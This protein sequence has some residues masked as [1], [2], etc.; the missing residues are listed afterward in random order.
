MTTTHEINQKRKAFD[1]GFND[2]R[3]GFSP[4]TE[5]MR[6]PGND[7]TNGAAYMTGWH[8][9]RT[10][11]DDDKRFEKQMAEIEAEKKAAAK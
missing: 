2:G 8:R 11:Y 1:K 5:M 10:C 9:G 3:K 6:D 4:D 7:N